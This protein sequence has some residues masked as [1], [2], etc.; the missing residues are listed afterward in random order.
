LETP[1]IHL[2]SFLNTVCWVCFLWS[3]KCCFG[4]YVSQALVYAFL[5]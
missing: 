5:H 4:V 3:R 2:S 1:G